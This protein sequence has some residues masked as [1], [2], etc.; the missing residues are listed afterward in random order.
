MILVEYFVAFKGAINLFT[1][2]DMFLKWSWKSSSESSN[3]PEYFCDNTYLAIELPKS[4]WVW[5]RFCILRDSMT[6]W[7]CF[8][9]LGL[10]VIFQQNF[11]FLVLDKSTLKSWAEQ[12]IPWTIEKSEVLSANNFKFDNKLSEKSLEKRLEKRFDYRIHVTGQNQL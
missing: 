3:M 8:M 2:F 10:K 11:Q 7:A 12:F 1:L 9:G 5:F 4:N 6:S